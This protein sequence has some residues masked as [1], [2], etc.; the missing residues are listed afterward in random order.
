MTLFPPPL[1]QG[2][3]GRRGYS[4]A[5]WAPNAPQPPVPVGTK[6]SPFSP[7]PVPSRCDYHHDGDGDDG[8][9]SQFQFVYPPHSMVCKF[10]CLRFPSFDEFIHT[11][12]YTLCVHTCTH[13]HHTLSQGVILYRFGSHVAFSCILSNMSFIH[14]QFVCMNDM[15][16]PRIFFLG[17]FTVR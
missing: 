13:I 8:E 11:Y 14:T 10:S 5:S 9:E 17:L 4:P 6:R 12:A 16:P 2:P 7:R 15:V 3:P 1:P